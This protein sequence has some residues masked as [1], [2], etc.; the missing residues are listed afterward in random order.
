MRYP[1]GQIAKFGDVVIVAGMI[2]KVVCSIDTG[3]YS[4]AYPEV[5]WAYLQRGVMI[6]WDRQGPTRYEE[7]E[8]GMILVR[9]HRQV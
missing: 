7:P 5:A 3:E 9:R 1:D 4:D 6:D 8:A 2:G